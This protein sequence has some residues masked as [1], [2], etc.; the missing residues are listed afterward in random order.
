MW[1]S[2]CVGECER[3]CGRG[4]ERVCWRDSVGEI[5]LESVW[6]RECVGGCV[7]E[8]GRVCGESVC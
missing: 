5:A 4:G 8:R 7:W 3:V 1:E 6:E 2:V